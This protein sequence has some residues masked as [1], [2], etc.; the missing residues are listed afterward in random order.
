MN[1]ATEKT[2]R[3]QHLDWCKKR[4]LEYCDMGDTAQAFAS[5]VSDLRKDDS[6]SNHAAIEFGMMLL[7]GGHLSTDQ[8]M[9]EFIEG[10][11]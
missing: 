5:M 7:M 4:A 11:N 2:P 10:F 9:R 3:Q 6:T 8:Q 1:T